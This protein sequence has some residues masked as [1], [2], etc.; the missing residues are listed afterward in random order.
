VR[1]DV[2]GNTLTDNTGYGLKVM[3]RPQGRITGN[4][5]ARNRR[6]R[7]NQRP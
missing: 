6:G 3:R 7:T 2:V 1:N 4:T 5:F